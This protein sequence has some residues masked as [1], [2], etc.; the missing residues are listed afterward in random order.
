MKKKVLKPMIAMLLA[1]VMVLSGL[2][3]FGSSKAKAAPLSSGDSFMWDYDDWTDTERFCFVVLPGEETV[4]LSSFSMREDIPKTVEVPDKVSFYDEENDITYSYTV[5]G[6][7]SAFAYNEYIESVVLPNTIKDLYSAYGTG[8]FQGCTNLKSVDLPVQL[9]KIG[10]FTFMDCKSLST[11][12]LPETVMTIG[13]GAFQGCKSITEII[14][15]NGLTSLGEYAFD[16]C[17]NL[18]SVDIKYTSLTEIPRY[19]FNECGS[20]YSIEL[21]GTVTAIGEGAFY[22]CTSLSGINIPDSVTS[23]ENE[24]FYECENLTGINGLTEVRVAEGLT[25]ISGR[26]FYGCN[27]QGT[28]TIPK[29]V[30]EI[31]AAA[32]YKN[33]GLKG[34][35]FETGSKLETIEESAFR[36][37][38]GLS[39][40]LDLPEGLKNI[41]GLSFTGAGFNEVVIPSTLEYLSEYFMETTNPP[42][43]II[44]KSGYINIAITSIN[45]AYKYKKDSDSQI[46][47]N[48][49]ELDNKVLLEIYD[50]GIGISSK[51]IERVFEKSFTGENGRCRVKSTGMGLYII[52]KLCD[53]LGHNIKIESKKNEFTKV[54]LE[55]G[56]NE[57]YKIVR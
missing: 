26:A 52:K 25:K 39:G 2:P 46:K 38:Y 12:V 33:E 36:Y 40:K 45:A 34:I 10:D 41:Y 16:Q 11:I 42:S 20:L 8:A 5:T 51:D 15:P 54:T 3:T 55:F 37:C 7:G 44:N 19:T 49:I 53:K 32:F 29:N 57:Y 18:K 48:C 47:I 50:N 9:E 21:P 35:S 30:T 14:T 6:I 17:E 27:L 43:K 56:K 1:I 4:E 31:G 13:F 23:I 22:K 24:A 28:L